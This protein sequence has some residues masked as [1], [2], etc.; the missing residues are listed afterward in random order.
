MDGIL[1]GDGFFVGLFC[2]VESF[3]AIESFLC[4]LSK[5]RLKRWGSSSGKSGVEI[6]FI[7]G[8]ITGFPLRIKLEWR[9][10]V[11]PGETTVF[12]F[13]NCVPTT[14]PIKGTWFT[15]AIGRDC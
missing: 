10:S 1:L 7:L 13:V 5:I 9:G 4:K 15:T 6:Q 2:A 3:C 14:Y 12:A 8:E 11:V